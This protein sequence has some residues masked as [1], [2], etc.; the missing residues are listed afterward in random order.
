MPFVCG[1]M[2]KIAKNDPELKSTQKGKH[3]CNFTLAVTEGF[4]ER[5]KTDYFRC[6]A[7][8]KTANTI[9]NNFR[10]GD[11]L[12][13]EGRMENNSYKKDENG[14]DIPNWQILVSR[15]HFLPRPKVQTED[16]DYD[17]SSNAAMQ[18]SGVNGSADI[19]YSDTDFAPL[20]EEISD[21]PF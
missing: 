4:G 12:I 3:Y 15:I 1:W 20:D 16:E 13:V 2:G 21:L 9:C 17:Y 5:K 10:R 8:E 6:V 14:Y 7:W 18:M 11:S 19:Q